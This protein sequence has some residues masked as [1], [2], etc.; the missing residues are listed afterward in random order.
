MRRWVSLLVLISML[1]S[2]I[3]PAQ[4]G[5]AEAPE[6][7]VPAFYSMDNP[8]LMQYIED[9]VYANME[10]ALDDDFVVQEISAVYLTPEYIEELEYYSRKNNYFGY[11][12]DELD[13][14]FA[15][16]RYV[17]TLGENHETIVKK[18]EAQD[19]SYDLLTM[20]RD[21][22]VGSGVILICVVV[23]FFT[24][25]TG[26][27]KTIQILHAVSTAAMKQAIEEAADGVFYSATTAA[28][29]EM[30]DTGDPI[31]ALQAAA[32]AGSEGYRRG[33]IV[34]TA[35]GTLWS[36]AGLR[37]KKVPDPLDSEHKT[38]ELFDNG[39]DV[40][41]QVSYYNREVAQPGTESSTRPDIIRWVD[42]HL[43]AIEVKNYD[44]KRHL[45]QLSHTL[46]KQV[47]DRVQHLPEGSTQRIVLDFRNRGYTQFFADSVRAFIQESLMDIYPN[48]PVDFIWV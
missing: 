44:C 30:K 10:E 38:L 5:F 9:S 27:P 3:V 6:D 47:S 2:A 43:E 21:V 40:R 22:A 39:N 1:L 37:T 31:A 24:K 42:D 13:A 32:V 18:V 11:E 4:A 8:A 29:A 12:L 41:T 16:S 45:S 48:I 15:G 19:N 34:G 33:A 46:R 20:V 26:T 17:F 7:S 25:G 14:N 35:K 23:T 28:M 36:L